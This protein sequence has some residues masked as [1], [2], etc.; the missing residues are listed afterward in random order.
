MDS[1]NLELIELIS[2]PSPT[3]IVL[4]VIDG[5][6]GLP[7]KSGK[8]E[9]E[10]ARTPNMNSLAE[11]GVCGLIDP[12]SPGV[13]P[14]SSPAHLALFGYNPISFEVGRGVVEAVGIDFDLE[15]EDIAA[16]GNFCTVN[17]NGLVTDRRAG[18]ISTEECTRLCKLLD[19][20]VIDKVKILVRPVRGHR[21]VAIFRGEG[22][23][24]DISDSDLQHT[25]AAPRSINALC[26]EASRMASVANQFMDKAKAVLAKHH[27]ANM[28]LLRGFSQRPHFPT[29]GEIYGLKPAAIASYPM[30]RGIAKLVG[31]EVLKTGATMEA[32]FNTLKQNYAG[33]DFFFLH[34]K[35]ADL[36]G[37]DGDFEGKVR[38]IE[39]ADRA[40]ATLISLKPDVI[41][42][43][44]DHSTPATLKGHSWHPVPVL[45]SS[46]W[47]RP[48]K[49]REFSESTCV[50]GGLGRLPA[51]QVMPLAM[52][53][54]GKLTK[55]GA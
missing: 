21:L 26:L 2:T 38:V 50:S 45:L 23:L 8:T 42:V 4:V 3:K 10:T 20:L 7:D 31:M 40:L 9:L 29:M 25:G 52:A 12:V 55:F 30:Y 34:I 48:D 14:G 28:V 32:E 44:G 6:G 19:G 46:K 16:R 27:P 22:L 5:L 36:A 47:C 39:E 51:T 17:K 53:H 54:A 1:V 13:T 15:G 43:T 11:K 18:R 24:P 41:V 35:E 49:V 37:E 33:Y